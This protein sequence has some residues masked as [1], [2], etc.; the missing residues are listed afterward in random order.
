MLY[1]ATSNNLLLHYLAKMG[2]HENCIFHSANRCLIS[3]ILLTPDL[4]RLCC[5]TPQNL[6][7]NVFSSRLLGGMV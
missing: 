6:V 7:I 2:K 1:Y 5:M 4:I 3:L